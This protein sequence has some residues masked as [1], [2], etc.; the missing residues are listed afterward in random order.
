MGVALGGNIGNALMACML[1]ILYAISHTKQKDR[2]LDSKQAGCYWPELARGVIHARARGVIHARVHVF[3][4][5]AAH[6]VEAVGTA[7]SVKGLDVGVP[8]DIVLR[9]PLHCFDIAA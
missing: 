1:E 9:S 6:L 4:Q 2:Q 3:E 5:W 8:Q 7:L